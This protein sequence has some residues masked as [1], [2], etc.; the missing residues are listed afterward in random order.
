MLKRRPDHEEEWL[1]GL[2]D[3][4][5]QQRPDAKAGRICEELWLLGQ[6]PLKSYLDFVDDQVVDGEAAD[7]AGL[8]AEWRAANE[9]YQELERREAGIANQIERRALEP[10]VAALAAQAKAHPRFR[11]AFETLETSFAM[12]E[13]DRLMV[14]QKHVSRTFVDELMARIGPA[15]GD[16][17]LF[18][19][20]MPL[21]MRDCPVTMRREGSRR[22]TFRCESTDFRYLESK[23]LRPEQISGYDAF[24]PLAGVVGLM[25]GFGSNFLNAVAVGKRLLLNNG[26]HRACALRAAGITH[27][28]CLVQT[29]GTVDELEVVAKS[30]VMDDPA[31][32]FESARP[33]LL[34]DFS[35]PRICKLLRVHRR[36]RV[37]EVSFEIN[38]FMVN[39]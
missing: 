34:K 13:L 6:P 24:G 1:H 2:A 10:A 15:P 29:A 16:A 19:F 23:L 38:D 11:R 20:C 7:R 21:G 28:P 35:D 36:R 31:F 3:P 5:A 30:E 26:Y 18:E 4:F 33:P 37:I 14:F 27:A 17:A 9:Y 12:V 8:A 39:L 25:V 22:Y 32:Y